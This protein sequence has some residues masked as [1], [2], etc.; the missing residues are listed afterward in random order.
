MY[1]CLFLRTE[2]IVVLGYSLLKI[3]RGSAILIDFESAFDP[4]FDFHWGVM[5]TSF[6]SV[7]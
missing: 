3:A 7:N 1:D 2:R 6:R 4:G 5:G